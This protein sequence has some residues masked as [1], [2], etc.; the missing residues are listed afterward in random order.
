MRRTTRTTCQAAVLWV[1]MLGVSHS[2]A[3]GTVGESLLTPKYF[4][5]AVSLPHERELTSRIL[6]VSEQE[7][8]EAVLTAFATQHGFTVK[9]SGITV[10]VF[11][12]SVAYNSET[13]LCYEALVCL[14]SGEQTSQCEAIVQQW[15][16]SELSRYKDSLEKEEVSC[17]SSEMWNLGKLTFEAYARA[18]LELEGLNRNLVCYPY[19]VIPTSSQ[20]GEIY[21]GLADREK[22]RHPK[23]TEAIL[24]LLS[25]TN[26]AREIIIQYNSL[27]PT[28]AYPEFGQEAMKILQSM[29]ASAEKHFEKLIDMLTSAIGH[30]YGIIP[31]SQPYD[32]LPLLFQDALRRAYETSVTQSLLQEL[33]FA[34]Q[35]AEALARSRANIKFVPAVAVAVE[36]ADRVIQIEIV[37]VSGTDRQIRIR[38]QLHSRSEK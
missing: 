34:K 32:R 23:H 13:V 29:Y 31:G 5:I 22:K 30:A 3:Q 8:D 12:P 37:A 2:L 35:P 18:N 17:G 7:A 9:R 38:H 19:K 24:Y 36:C 21:N 10:Y 26:Q 25:T 20:N 15:V 4:L 11:S 16:R 14:L 6:A 28:E 33:G 27:V 1:A